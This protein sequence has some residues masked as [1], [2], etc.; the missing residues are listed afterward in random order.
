MLIILTPGVI[1]SLCPI[2]KLCND[3]FLRIVP[4]LTGLLGMMGPGM[5]GNV[6]LGVPPP[7]ILGSP[8]M[9]N[10]MPQPVGTSFNPQSKYF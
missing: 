9:L 6:P 5:L 3:K 10:R 4:R 7:G 8:M 2:S 1:H